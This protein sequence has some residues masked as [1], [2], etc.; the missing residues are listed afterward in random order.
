[1]FILYLDESGVPQN[2]PSQTSH[3]VFLGVAVHEGAWSAL[4]K[5]VNDVKSGYALGDPRDLEL[6]AAWL[7]RPVHEQ[8][9]VPEFSSL[10]YTARRQA[11][12]SVRGAFEHDGLE[13]LAGRKREEWRRYCRNT[14]AI[15]HLTLE[16]RRVLYR[17]SLTV[18]GSHTRGLYLFAEAIDK[19]ALP[20][21]VDPVEQAFTQVVARFDAFLASRTDRKEWGLLAV[22]RDEHKAG[23]LQ[24]LLAQFQRSGTAW[25]DIDRVIEAPFFFDSRSSSGV[26][27]TDLCSYALRRYLEKQE[28]DAFALIF[29]K[30]FRSKGKLHGV[31]HYTRRGSCTCLI[32]TERG[33]L[34]E[35]TSATPPPAPAKRAKPVDSR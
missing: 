17:R 19:G 20:A 29:P 34:K 32:C 4:E 30:F 24:T 31:R 33:F 12:L 5:R 8:V 21:G 35:P 2:H 23:Q 22:D 1:M 18:I 15:L 11:V 27:V 13:M 26:Q 3:Y 16:E 25:R 6:H 28:V 10:T 14:D 7:L 9:K